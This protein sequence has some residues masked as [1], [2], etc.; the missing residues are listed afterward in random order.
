MASR[1]HLNSRSLV[2][3]NIQGR[4]SHKA[5]VEY[6]PPVGNILGDTTCTRNMKSACTGWDMVFCHVFSSRVAVQLNAVDNKLIAGTTQ[7]FIQ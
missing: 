5:Y 1:H 4:C 3:R 2:V 7:L 6:V